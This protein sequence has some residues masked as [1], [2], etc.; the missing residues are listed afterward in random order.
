MSLLLTSHSSCFRVLPRL[1]IRRMGRTSCVYRISNTAA[2]KSQ[3]TSIMTCRVGKDKKKRWTPAFIDALEGGRPEAAG[4]RATL[5]ACGPWAG[6]AA[7]LGDLRRSA[8]G[9]DQCNRC[10]LWLE[11]IGTAW[12]EVH[13]TAPAR[14]PAGTCESQVPDAT[15]EQGRE[16]RCF[17]AGTMGGAFATF[18]R[19]QNRSATWA[20]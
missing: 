15:C 14:P 4:G 8:G 3:V 17:T 2:S 18:L 1:A 10:H 12:A 9:L 11:P 20:G 19:E 7:D 6:R 16:R 13:P 5:P